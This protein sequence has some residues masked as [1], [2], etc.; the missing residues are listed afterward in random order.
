M[1]SP[2]AY[3]KSYGD[4]KYLEARD[5][6]DLI[7]ALAEELEDIEAEY[8]Y[9]KYDKRKRSFDKNDADQSTL[10]ATALP[11]EYQLDAA[12]KSVQSISPAPREKSLID[13]TYKKHLKVGWSNTAANRL[14]LKIRNTRRIILWFKNSYSIELRKRY[15]Y[16]DS[17]IYIGYGKYADLP[18]NTFTS[19]LA[20]LLFNDP[21]KIWLMSD[22]IDELA[23]DKNITFETREYDD[24]DYLLIKRCCQSIN[25][26]VSAVKGSKIKLVD[27]TI[28]RVK[29]NTKLFHV[30]DRI[31]VE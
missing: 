9:R 23:K 16:E 8:A 1:L 31:T 30:L 19:S 26:K 14:E 5:H 2:D 11:L 22:L 12:V 18:E 25:D 17:S 7:T 29:L 27:C 21:R 24:I 6:T 10:H 13:K 20:K 15:W 3:E 4:Q 28:S